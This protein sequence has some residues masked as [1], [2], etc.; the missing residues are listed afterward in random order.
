MHNPKHEDRE[1]VRVDLSKTVLR[2][3]GK[4]AKEN[5]KSLSALVEETLL[6]RVGPVDGVSERGTKGSVT[7]DTAPSKA[8]G[9]P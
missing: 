7:E 6:D 9:R 8:P 4:L 3:A 5:G 1:R 2:A